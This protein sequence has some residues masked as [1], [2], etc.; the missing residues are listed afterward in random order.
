MLDY[1]IRVLEEM[2]ELNNRRSKLADFIGLENGQ[3]STLPQPE[4]RRLIQQYAAMDSYH[5]ILLER[6]ANFI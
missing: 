3:F 1:Q 2:I 6:I 5:K 4:R